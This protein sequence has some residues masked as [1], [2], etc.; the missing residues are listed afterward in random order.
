MASKVFNISQQCCIVPDMSLEDN[1]VE[2]DDLSIEDTMVEADELNSSMEQQ[3]ESSGGIFRE[4]ES[5]G[6]FIPMG[7]V[8]YSPFTI[9]VFPSKIQNMTSLKVC[10]FSPLSR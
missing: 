6:G 5:L 1:M 2:P 3:T 10:F 9:K 7:P 4:L 8:G